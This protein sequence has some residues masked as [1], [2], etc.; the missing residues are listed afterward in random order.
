MGEGGERITH[1]ILEMTALGWH[2]IELLM[3]SGYL[4]PLFDRP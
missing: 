4:L 1:G 3:L 2:D